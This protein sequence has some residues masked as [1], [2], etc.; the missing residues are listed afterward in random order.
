MGAI[1]GGLSG[2][3]R[4]LFIALGKHFLLCYDGG[5]A[6][7]TILIRKLLARANR[8]QFGLRLMLLLVAFFGAIVGW[9]SAV[10]QR[11]ALDREYKKVR[12]E[13]EI[14]TLERLFRDAPSWRRIHGP[15]LGAAKKELETITP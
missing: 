7:S 6:Q 8:P 13:A 12:I 3:R 1:S 14:A 15:R 9:R 10:S 11:R 5:M 4:P 2:P